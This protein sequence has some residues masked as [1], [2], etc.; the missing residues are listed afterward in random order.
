MVLKK[1][2]SSQLEIPTEIV[3]QETLLP[4]YMGGGGGGVKIFI[5]ENKFINGPAKEKK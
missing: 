4:K 1:C 2:V 3:S 5:M